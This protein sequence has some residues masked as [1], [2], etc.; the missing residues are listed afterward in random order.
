M[1]AYAFL[2]GAFDP[3]HIAHI[4]LLTELGKQLA[5]DKLFLMPYGISPT[6]KKL[7]ATPE[8]RKTMI[9]QALGGQSRLALEDCELENREPSYTYR[10]MEKLRNRYAMN[11]HISFVLGE[12]SYASLQSWKHWDRLIELVSLVV[13]NRGHINVPQSLTQ[14]EAKQRM[15]K[16]RFLNVAANHLLRVRIPFMDVSSSVI[17]GSIYKGKMPDHLLP[18]DVPQYI[19]A[20]KLYAA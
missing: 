14:W 10:T 18:A 13:I 5:Y 20:E 9:N 1:P 8:Q 4:R 15:D 3:V 12:D 16:R 7:Q 6:T 11:C 17:R 2:G 19:R